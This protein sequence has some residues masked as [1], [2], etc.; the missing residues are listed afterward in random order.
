VGVETPIFRS[1]HRAIDLG[2]GRDISAISV[3]AFK[4]GSLKAND[5]RD[6]E[7]ALERTRRR[8]CT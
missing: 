2:L 5:I 8:A 3:I 7:S 4:T 6:K 1:A